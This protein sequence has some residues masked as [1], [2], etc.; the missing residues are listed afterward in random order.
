MKKILL[1]IAV[2]LI[3][4][5]FAKSLPINV[6]VISDNQTFDKNQFQDWANKI[7]ALK[8]S[9]TKLDFFQS[10]FDTRFPDSWMFGKTNVN[11]SPI[12][13]DCQYDPCKSLKQFL[14]ERSTNRTKL[15]YGGGNFKCNIQSFGVESS[16]IKMD[17]NTI[18]SKIQE[19]NEINKSLKK[20]LTLVF[21]LSSSES[22]SSPIVS[23]E[24]DTIRIKKGER[25]QLTCSVEGDY[26]TLLWEPSIGLSCSNCDDPKLT[27]DKPMVY[28]VSAT[29]KY[30]CSSEREEVV[31]EPLKVCEGKIQKCEIMYSIDQNL[32]RK[33]LGDVSKWLMASSQPGSKIYY[34]VC[35]PNCGERFELSLYDL[36]NRK[37][38]TEPFKLNDVIKGQKLHQ[39]YPDYFIFKVNLNKYE[40]DTKDFY[41]FEIKTSDDEGN[42][43]PKYSSPATK[44]V[45]CGFIE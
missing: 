18:I 21:Y 5:V 19:E 11:Y 4:N 3:S 29:N 13:V 39:D 22:F 41:R 31:I 30:G 12:K 43:Y 14:D 7:V 36:N 28:T 37:I 44:F 6:Y 27:V 2:S 40:F 25:L 38:M 1:F 35:E 10:T 45:D 34:L 17:I 42:N 23:I 26:N 16:P 15:F 9:Y 33:V 32:Y 20:N 24:Q 8:V